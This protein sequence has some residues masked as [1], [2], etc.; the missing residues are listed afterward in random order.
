MDG[1]NPFLYFIMFEAVYY[2]IIY[3]IIKCALQI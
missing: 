3:I 1:I 2:T